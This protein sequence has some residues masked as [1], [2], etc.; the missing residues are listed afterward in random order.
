VHPDPVKASGDLRDE[1]TDFADRYLAGQAAT[2]DREE[3]LP[4]DVV[5]AVATAGY[6][7]SQAPVEQGGRGLDMAAYGALHLE[8]GKACSSVRSL[9]TVHDMVVEAVLRLGGER[10]RQTWLPRLLAEGKVA[11]FALSEPDAGSDAA[12][13]ATV[14]KSDGAGYVLHGSKRWISFAQIADVFLVIARLEETGELAG[15][16]VPRDTEGLEITPMSGMLGLR[17]SMLGELRL[18]GCPVAAD[19][20]VGARS[21]PGALIA[22]TPLQL[23]RY[24]VAWG[25]VAIAEAC[26][27][28]A[29]SYAETREQFGKPIADHQLIARKLTDMAVETEAARLLCSR[30]SQLLDAASPDAIGA[31]LMAKYHASRTAVAVATDAVQIHGAVGVHA[32]SPVERWFRDARIMEI[33]EGSSEIQQLMIARRERARFRGRR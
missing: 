9:L 4:R 21:M 5:T 28:A 8:I 31:V 10:L 24:G 33:I 25:S 16:L 1:F 26:V 11:A 20:R 22:A 6:L 2:F 23:G 15:F 19:A 13:I 3:R 30:A 17:A 32:A 18:D 7:G 12:N 29:Y 27:E 14:A